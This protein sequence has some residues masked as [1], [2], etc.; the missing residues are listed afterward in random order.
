MAKKRFCSSKILSG[1]FSCI[2]FII[3]STSFVKVCTGK[4]EFF[5]FANVVILS[6]VSEIP[7]PFSAE[8]FITLQPNLL[9]SL[10][11]CI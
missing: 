10:S 5:C 4:K 9:L 6:T 8:I 2:D 11:I 3:S 1:N 7:I